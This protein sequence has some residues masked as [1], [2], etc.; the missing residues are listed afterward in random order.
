MAGSFYAWDSKA[1]AR[2]SRPDWFVQEDGEWL[3]LSPRIEY[4]TAGLPLNAPVMAEDG[5]TVATPSD[6]SAPYVVL[7]PNADG[8]VGKL[9]APYNHLGFAGDE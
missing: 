5:E 9:I 2:Q 8:P 7:S 3:V 6:M 4:A 1:K